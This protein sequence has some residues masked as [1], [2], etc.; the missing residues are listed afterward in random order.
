MEWWLWAL[1]GLGLAGC[2]MLT[3]AGLPVPSV[4]H[5]A[6]RADRRGTG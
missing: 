6:D 5:P 1:I 3:P 4:P 2:E